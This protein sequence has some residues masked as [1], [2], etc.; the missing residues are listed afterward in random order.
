MMM[1][2]MTADDEGGGATLWRG[3][4]CFILRYV[5]L[6]FDVLRTLNNTK[7]DK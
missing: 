3:S 2:A 7:Q 5:P 4:L 1:T 6:E